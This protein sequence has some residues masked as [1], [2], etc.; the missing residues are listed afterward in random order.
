MRV[1]LMNGLLEVSRDTSKSPFF[2]RVA[3]ATS[4]YRIHA[5]PAI[6]SK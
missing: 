2:L 6:S 3:H 4:G 5:K 1:N